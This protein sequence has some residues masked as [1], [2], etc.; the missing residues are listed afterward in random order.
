M[1]ETP[2][3]PGV[4]PLCQLPLWSSGTLSAVNGPEEIVARLEGL[5]LCAGR[6]VTLLQKGDPTI[7][8]VYGSR[9]GLA[10]SLACYLNVNSTEIDA[11][12]A[13]PA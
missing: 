1:S 13:P 11:A 7:V 12:A 5:G 3:P 6:T 4:T 9:I 2:L 8:Q 10:Q